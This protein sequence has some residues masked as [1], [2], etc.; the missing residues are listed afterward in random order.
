MSGLET[1]SSFGW[2]LK[3]LEVRMGWEVLPVEMTLWVSSS[4]WIELF[5]PCFPS[6]S[7]LEAVEGSGLLTVGV[8]GLRGPGTVG[9]VSTPGLGVV[10]TLGLGV[11]GGTGLKGSCVGSFFPLKIVPL[12]G[13]RILRLD[14]HC[15]RPQRAL[16][17]GF[18]VMSQG[19]SWFLAH[20]TLR[21]RTPPPQETEHWKR[22]MAV[23]RVGKTRCFSGYNLQQ[24]RTGP[25]ETA[26][27]S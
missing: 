5:R 13:F 25:V 1:F 3:D 11:V 26:L 18:L 16:L 27:C 15:W 8:L 23:S 12:L 20:V 19:S 24:I 2:M 9:V 22:E 14:G 6:R 7:P 10:S 17:L 4:V 21:I